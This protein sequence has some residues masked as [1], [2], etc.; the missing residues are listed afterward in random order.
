MTLQNGLVFKGEWLVVHE[1]AREEMKAKIHAS[2]IGIQ[3]CLSRARE[4]IYWPR[5]NKDIK[6]CIAKCVVCNNQPMEQTK[7]PMI[8]HEIPTSLWEKIAVDL[9]ELSGR[10]YMITVDY[11]SSSF[12]IDSLTTKTVDEVIG[13]LKAQLARHGIPDQLVSDSK[14][15]RGNPRPILACFLRYQDHETVLCAGFELKDTEYTILQDS[16]QET[17]ERK[18]KQMPKLKEA[19]KKGTKKYP[20]V[21][22]NLINSLLMASSFLN[23]GYINC[24]LSSL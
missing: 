18:R 12:E 2:H 5:M 16:P 19:K 8:C 23:R 22:Q 11:F 4:V 6:N 20:L 15:I 7:E 17:I 24:D 9:F 3:G 21:D 10:D 13:K 1:S 14:S